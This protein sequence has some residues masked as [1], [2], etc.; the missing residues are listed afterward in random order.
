MRH[1]ALMW[2]FVGRLVA[3]RAALDYDLRVAGY[4]PEL[5]GAAGMLATNNMHAWKL[6]FKEK[7]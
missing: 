2:G 6:V 1:F 4:D 7:P 3:L 5:A